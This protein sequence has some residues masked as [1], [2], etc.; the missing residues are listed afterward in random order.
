[1]EAGL[2][3]VEALRSAT[4]EPAGYFGLTGRGVIASGKRADLLLVE[5]DPTVS[6]GDIR[7]TKGVWIKG[8][9]VPL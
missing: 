3:P 8:E 7:N 4:G 9:Q 5:G 1:V 2:T 6:I